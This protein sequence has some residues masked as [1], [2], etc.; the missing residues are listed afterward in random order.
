M[1]LESPLIAPSPADP[2]LSKLDDPR[3]TAALSD[4][5]DHADLLAVL[6]VGLDGLLRRG[7]EVNGA[8]GD[9]LRFLQDAA[10]AGG[11]D[12]LDLPKLASSLATLSTLVRD[13]APTLEALVH[14]DLADQRLI[15]VV[16]L[17]ARSIITGT[18]QARAEPVRASGVFSLMRALKDD[19][20][21]RGV[22]FMIQVARAFGKEL[23]GA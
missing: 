11:L 5:L 1:A 2:L 19:D 16:S 8:L 17:A 3:V 9:A 21:A 18:E 4:L 15:D 20:V 7:E 6:V 14:S 23:N 10:S 13:A 12:Q 22:G